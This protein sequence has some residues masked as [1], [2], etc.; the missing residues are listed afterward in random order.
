VP[1]A[2]RV[3]A[4]SRG[5]SWGPGTL[6]LRCSRGTLR[7][8]N[9]KLAAASPAAAMA[10]G[11]RE[12]AVRSASGYLSSR[13]LSSDCRTRTLCTTWRVIEPS[14][15]ELES[16][17]MASYV[18]H[19]WQNSAAFVRLVWALPLSSRQ[20]AWQPSCNHR[21]EVDAYGDSEAGVDGT[22]RRES[23][24]RGQR[25]VTH[26]QDVNLHGFD[27]SIIQSG[28]YPHR[29]A[30]SGN[31]AEYSTQ[32]I[33]R[34]SLQCVVAGMITVV[35]MSTPGWDFQAAAHPQWAA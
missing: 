12:F 13:A 33:L 18:P 26:R 1:A 17:R 27:G 35:C 31:A 19:H 34:S 25:S 9:R 3:Q 7:A 30:E 15:F 4:L 28:A 14:A 16:N 24:N 11:G 29:R 10:P 20:E 8:S 5:L 23:S 32:L 21:R 22:H 6:A 2:V